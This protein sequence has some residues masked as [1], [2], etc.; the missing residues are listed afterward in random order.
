MKPCDLLVFTSF[1]KLIFVKVH[2]P[3]FADSCTSSTHDILR[4]IGVADN[5]HE[6]SMSSP[7][8]PQIRCI[9]SLLS[10]EKGYTSLWLRTAWPIMNLPSLIGECQSCL[11]RK[12]LKLTKYFHCRRYKLRTVGQ[13]QHTAYSAFVY[14]LTVH[15]IR[16]IQEQSQTAYDRQGEYG[17]DPE[18]ISG[19][20]LWIRT[21]D[22]D[23]F[24]K[25]QRGLTCP[26][27]H[28]W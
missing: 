3:S 20:G 23:Y 8:T 28:L 21:S 25:S 16:N 24:Q 1:L 18:S 22:L 13:R 4:C 15:W 26:R 11:I 12:Q 19:Y 17:L 27:I 5:Q 6:H 10:P 7:P 9:S 2:W 14:P